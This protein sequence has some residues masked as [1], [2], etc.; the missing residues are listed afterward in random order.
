MGRWILL[1]WFS[2]GVTALGA[3]QGLDSLISPDFPIDRGPHGKFACA[4]CHRSS[5]FFEFSC[6]DCHKHSRDKMDDKHKELGGYT[7]DS[8]ACYSC[9]PGGRS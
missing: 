2:F 7:Y 6:T 5:S 8:R 9:H 4:E 1:G 3:G